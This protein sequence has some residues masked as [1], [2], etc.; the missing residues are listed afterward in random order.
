MG[1]VINVVTRQ[2]GNDFHG[3]VLGYLQRLR[4]STA[5]RGTL[6]ASILTTS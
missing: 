6:F 1:G 3:D 4:R 2:G 5:R